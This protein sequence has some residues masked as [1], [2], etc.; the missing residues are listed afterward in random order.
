MKSSLER[1]N[2]STQEENTIFGAEVLRFHLE[3]YR[4]AGRHL[5]PGLIGDIAC[6][7][8]YGSNI[9]ITEFPEKIKRILAVDNYAEAIEYARRTYQHPL[10]DFQLQDAQTLKAALSFDTVVCFETLEHLE[11]PAEFVQRIS[12]HIVKGGKFIVSVPITP[13]MDANPYHLHDFTSRKL[14]KICESSNLFLR[15]NFIQQ[16]KYNPFLLASKTNHRTDQLRKNI[17]NYYLNHPR[18][19]FLRLKSILA[20]GFRNKYYVGVFEKGQ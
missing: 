14:N 5:A 7:T 11:H 16:Q 20:D 15:H 12:N 2:P 4:Y 18:K 6:G 19:F 8:G 9:L 13:S 1:F 17:I 10:I 3:R